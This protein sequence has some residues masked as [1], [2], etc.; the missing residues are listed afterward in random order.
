MHILA[1]VLSRQATLPAIR[2]RFHSDFQWN[3]YDA[4]LTSAA[5]LLF[6]DVASPAYRACGWP[7]QD[8][9][10]RRWIAELG[11]RLQRHADAIVRWCLRTM[12]R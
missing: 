8:A 12:V 10:N 7:D 5:A 11:G 1:Q 2:Y 6:L 3:V 4:V 9:A